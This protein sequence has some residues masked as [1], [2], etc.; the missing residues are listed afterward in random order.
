VT[1][2]SDGMELS[3]NKLAK[4]L[5]PLLPLLLPPPRRVANQPMKA[6]RKAKAHPREKAGKR[7]AQQLQAKTM[8]PTILFHLHLKDFGSFLGAAPP[9]A[10]ILPVWPGILFCSLRLKMVECMCGFSRAK[11]AEAFVS[12]AAAVLRITW[13]R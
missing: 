11:A 4:T 2:Q 3:K 1:V 7:R 13:F 8:M 12:V 6:K 9:A 5:L 10:S